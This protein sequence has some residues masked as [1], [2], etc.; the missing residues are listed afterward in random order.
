MKKALGMVLLLAASALASAAPDRATVTFSNGTEG[1][2]GVGDGAGGSWISGTPG[3]HGAAYYTNVPMTF[4]LNWINNSNRDFVFN[5]GKARKITIGIDVKVNSITYEGIE[6]PRALVVELR[7]Y[8]QP[9]GDAP[10]TSVWYKLGTISAARRGWQ[11]LS[12]TIDDTHAKHLPSGWGGY[13][14]G[15]VSLPAGSSFA[16]VLANIDEVAFTTYV[17]GM[18]YG[19]TSFDVAVDNISIKA[20]EQH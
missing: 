4:G 16:S 2:V 15:G 20:H 6:V 1:W 8:H 3:G 7:D 12:V 13:G 14:S 10:Y 5:Y 19:Y 11:H 18:F 17:P 9:R